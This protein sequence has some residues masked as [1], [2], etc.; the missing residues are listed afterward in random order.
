MEMS[1][2]DVVL[3]DAGKDKNKVVLAL[4]EITAREQAL[5]MLDL[6]RAKQLVESTPCVV[7]PNVHSDRRKPG[8]SEIGESRRYR[9]SESC[10]T[11]R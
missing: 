3:V 10:L 11:T 2:V 8:E 1:F 4:R 9:Q 6:A 5:G 7:A